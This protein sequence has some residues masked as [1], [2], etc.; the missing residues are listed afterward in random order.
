LE[1]TDGTKQL[2][3]VV[4]EDIKPWVK[5]GRETS[6]TEYIELMQ[7]QFDFD[8]AIIQEKKS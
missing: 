2:R 3:Y 6:E 8:S 1:K 4:T 7:E 5:A